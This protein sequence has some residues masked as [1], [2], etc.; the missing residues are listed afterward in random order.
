MEYS[1]L[2][3]EEVF[4]GTSNGIPIFFGYRVQ[5]SIPTIGAWVFFVYN[6]IVE[7]ISARIDDIEQKQKTI[8]NLTLTL[9]EYR[10]ISAAT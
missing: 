7:E 10:K 2:G 8:E 1:I 3:Y 5:V 6:L 9:K 4:N